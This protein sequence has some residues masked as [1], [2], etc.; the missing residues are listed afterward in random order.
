MWTN[1]T[2]FGGGELSWKSSMMQ[3]GEKYFKC[4]P[5]LLKEI[6]CHD[7]ARNSAVHHKT[8]Q[9]QFS[10]CST[11]AS[12][13]WQISIY[14]AQLNWKNGQIWGEKG[15]NPTTIF[16]LRDLFQIRNTVIIW[17]LVFYPN[18]STVFCFFHRNESHGAFPRACER[19]CHKELLK[20]CLSSQ[21]VPSRFAAVRDFSA[22]GNW[23]LALS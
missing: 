1:F 3:I 8:V 20:S 4:L 10:E 6:V 22:A 14:T 21:G 2:P 16:H 15:L 17:I 11:N 23:L 7:G 19:R 18:P 5:G 13:T 9:S 12:K